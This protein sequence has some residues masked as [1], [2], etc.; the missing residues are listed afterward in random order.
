MLCIFQEFFPPMWSRHSFNCFRGYQA[1][2][3]LKQ[4]QPQLLHENLRRLNISLLWT[5]ILIFSAAVTQKN[6]YSL[7]ENL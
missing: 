2:R 7:I 6:K 5:K 1:Q 4:T 3:V